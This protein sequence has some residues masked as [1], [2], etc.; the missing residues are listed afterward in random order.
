MAAVF[1][2]ESNEET[3]LWACV[4]VYLHDLNHLLALNRGEPAASPQPGSSSP[5]TA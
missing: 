3:V 2:P 1:R 4:I 5:Q